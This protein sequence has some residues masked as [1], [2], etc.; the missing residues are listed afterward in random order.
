[1]EGGDN[2]IKSFRDLIVWQ[3][4]MELVIEVY[5]LTNQYPKEEL[6]GLT[7]HTRKTVISIPSNIAEGK[8]RGT[9]KD[10]RM[11]MVIAYGST[12]E[13]DTQ[14]EIAKRLNKTKHLDYSKVTGLLAE[15]SKMLNSLINKL[16]P[17]S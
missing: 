2:K 13:L 5:K 7:A 8:N 10:Y 17:D 6:Y 12:A 15:V 11:F 1:M 16:T 9:R 4:A 3:K 14:L